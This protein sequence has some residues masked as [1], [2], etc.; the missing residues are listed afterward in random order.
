MDVAEMNLLPS[1]KTL[2]DS[3]TVD[4]VLYTQY[5]ETLLCHSI[6][7]A[8][9]SN[10]IQKCLENYDNDNSTFSVNINIVNKKIISRIVEY[11]YT[12]EIDITAADVTDLTLAADILQIDR[13]KEKLSVC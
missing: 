5:N 3:Q 10:Y 1:L 6:V 7:A 13:L 4:L 11:F 9:N 2:Y 12:G 8:A